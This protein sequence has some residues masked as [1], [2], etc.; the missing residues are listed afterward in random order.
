MKIRD[1]RSIIVI[2]AYVALNSFILFLSMKRAET[3]FSEKGS[4]G[5]VAPEFTIIKTL[6]YFSLKDGIPQMSLAAESMQSQ[7]DSLAEFFYPKGVYNYQQKKESIKYKAER[8][9]YQKNKDLL[10]LERSVEISSSDSQYYA[11]QI[12]YYISKD[13]VIGA[14]NVKFIG[15]DL[16]SKD[17]IQVESNRMNAWPGQKIAHFTGDVRGT[18]TRAKK[19]EGKMDFRSHQLNMD[20]INSLA[21]LEG[22]VWLKRGTQQVTSGKADIYM[23]NYNKELKYFVLNDDVKVTEKLS[24]PD[25]ITERKA[26]AERLE[27]FGREQKMVLSGAPR[28]EQGA[29][30]IKGYRITIRE[31][32]DLV[33][34]DDAMS[35]M[36]VKKKEKTEEKTDEKKT[37]GIV[38]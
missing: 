29:D 1:I 20:G 3:E 17:M 18:M 7:G 19:Y 31:N 37:K 33:E 26:F 8:G 6:E 16:Q 30:V 25:G 10:F 28:V 24:T 23:E 32:V 11:D 2:L 12:D 35:D 4:H 21:H 27:G 38:K 36:K 34:V 22:D 13:F 9:T 15:E 14:G 5:G